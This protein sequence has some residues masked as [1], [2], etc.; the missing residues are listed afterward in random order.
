MPRRRSAHAQ[1]LNWTICDVLALAFWN[2]SEVDDM[3]F[4]GKS[5]LATGKCFQSTRNIL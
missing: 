2:T 1:T 4:F 5:L 3:I